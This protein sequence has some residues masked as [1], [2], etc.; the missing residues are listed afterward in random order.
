MRVGIGFDAHRLVPGRSLVLGGVKVPSPRGLEGHSD[1]DVLCHAIA[2]AL[3]GA[4]GAGDLG[5]LFPSEDPRWK[6]ALSLRFVERAAGMIAGKGGSIV[7]IDATIVLESPKVAGFVG[8]MRANLAKVMRVDIA[9]VGVK[10]TTTDGLGLVG[11]GEG[12]A[13]MAVALVQTPG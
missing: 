10:A 1:G 3:L 9:V 8:G 2:D 6:D 11:R 4:I 5:L 7:N 13:A 12:A